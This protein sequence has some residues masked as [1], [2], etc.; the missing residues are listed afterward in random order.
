MRALKRKRK[1]RSRWTVHNAASGLIGSAESGRRRREAWIPAGR[2][3]NNRRVLT[4]LGFRS[5]SRAVGNAHRNDVCWWL[6]LRCAEK[7]KGSCESQDI[8]NNRRKFAILGKERGFQVK[9]APW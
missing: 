9:R 7:Y 8:R 2:C 5:G 4:Q 1:R 6:E 3:Q